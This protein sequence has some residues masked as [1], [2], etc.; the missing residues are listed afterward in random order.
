MGLG[1]LNN[2][3][4][5]AVTPNFSAIFFF[6]FFGTASLFIDGISSSEPDEKREVLLFLFC[7][8][9]VNSTWLITFE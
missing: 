7:S 1:R 4:L 6:F 5:N 3:L 9:E 2:I 8:S